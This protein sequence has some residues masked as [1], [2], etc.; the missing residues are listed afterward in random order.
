VTIFQKFSTTWKEDNLL[1][2]IVRNSSYLFGSNAI[3]SV[4]SFVQTI[5]AVR[6][7]G[8]TN[9]GTVAI[10]QTFASNINRF[11]SFRMS[12]VVVKHLGPSL[13]DDKKQEAAVLVKAA[14]LTESAMSIIGF[15]A[16]VLLAPWASRVFA[17]DATKAPIFIFYGFII[18]SNLVYETSTGVLQAT[19]RFGHLARV[20]LVYSIITSFMIGGAYV[21]FRWGHLIAASHLLEAVLMAYVLGKTYVGISLVMLALRE[22]KLVLGPG[23]WKI[24]LRTLTEKRSL[25]TFAVNTNLN[26]TMNLLFRDNIPLY[27]ANLLSLEAV[28]YFKIAMTL[29]IPITLILDPFIAPTY[30]EISRTIARFQWD[31]TLRLLKRITAIT[32]GVVLAIW[33]AWAL[34]GW[35][36]IPTLYK[37]QALP[38][39]PLLLILIAGYGFASAFQWNRSLFLSLG[40]AGYPVLISLLTGIIELALIF[41]LVPHYGYLMMAVILSGYFIVSIGFITLRGLWEVRRKAL[42]EP[43]SPESD[44][45][46]PSTPE[47]PPEVQPEEPLMDRRPLK[48]RFALPGVNRWDWLAIVIFLSYAGWYFLGRLEANYPVVILSGDGGNIA[49][50]AAALDHPDWFKNDPALGDSNNIGI[51]ATIHIP[52]IR[53]LNHLTGDYGLA[54]AWLVFPETFLQLLGFY[55]LGRVL[56]KSR[57]WAFLLAFLT[58]MMVINIGLGEIWGVWRD[59]LPR[60]TFQSLLPFLLTLVLVWKD[61]PGRWPW[62]M[63]FAGLLVYVHPISA[64]AWGFAIWLSLWLL[65]PKGWNWKQ[66]ILVMLGLGILF[67]IP[68]IPF[69]FNYLSY[70]ARGQAA[71]YSTVMTVLQTYAPADLL[72]APAALGTFLWNMTRSL[73]LPVALIGFAATWLIKKGNR[74]LIKVVLLWAA[75]IFIVSILVPSVERIVELRFHILPLE[76]ELVRC[77]RYFVPLL[78][79]FWLWPLAELAPRLVNQQARRGVIGLGIVLFGFWA[80]TNRPDVS[81]MLR[82]ITCM[83]KARL[84][85]VSDRPIDGLIAALR[86]QTQPGDGVLFF[87]EDTATTSQT[88]SVRYA[89]LRPLVYTSRDSGILGYAD[90]SALAAWLETTAQWESLRAMADP[91]ERLKGLVPLAENLKADYLVIDF[92][93]APETLASLPVTVV[94]QN[95]GYILLKLRNSQGNSIIG[96]G[97]AETNRNVFHEDSRAQISEIIFKRVSDF[98]PSW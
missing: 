22:L 16:L 89:A 69:T 38:V 73:L 11:L 77:L 50:Y 53:A 10:V 74:T 85:C 34:T 81:A 4:L 82:V 44:L 46:P 3:S 94:M 83:A 67:L 41:T 68:L 40:K 27:M 61:R 80:A 98:V 93:V 19:H 90:R 56:F 84:V 21:L 87:N 28:G 62:L 57:F 31:T 48:R 92:E 91:Q 6:L 1:R 65:Q 37:S 12:E 13:A 8:L 33:A 52:L 2:R 14:G 58:A 97:F 96:V 45:H 29:I 78:L 88:L 55:C 20:N 51:Y 47:V 30:T 5:V 42:A 7:I 59:A 32:G 15:L 79:L 76:T 25:I 54:Y 39:Y 72:N 49:S 71:D 24:P 60:V 36:I 86:T 70:N 18:L 35:W 64:P 26:G 75:G 17:G 9:W 23:W 43:Q 95:N 66:R 63:I